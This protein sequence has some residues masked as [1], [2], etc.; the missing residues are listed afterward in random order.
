[1]NCQPFQFINKEARR[2]EL[3]QLKKAAHEQRIHQAKNFGL[4]QL[5]ISHKNIE[6]LK[7]NEDPNDAVYPM[8]DEGFRSKVA[9]LTRQVTKEVL[10]EALTNELD[11]KLATEFFK[12]TN[13]AQA[14][15][16]NK[17]ILTTLLF[18]KLQNLHI[19]SI[20]IATICGQIVKDPNKCRCC[21]LEKD[22]KVDMPIQLIILAS[23]LVNAKLTEPNILLHYLNK[24]TLSKKVVKTNDMIFKEV[25]EDTKALKLVLNEEVLGTAEEILLRTIGADFDDRDPAEIIMEKEPFEMETKK[26]AVKKVVAWLDNGKTQSLDP[27]ELAE[28]ALDEIMAQDMRLSTSPSMCSSGIDTENESES[29]TEGG[30]LKAIEKAHDLRLSTDSSASE[31]ETGTDTPQD[32][33]MSF[34][35][36][37]E[38]NNSATSEPT[39]DSNVDD[40]DEDSDYIDDKNEVPFIREF[41][42]NENLSKLAPS[43]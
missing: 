43:F 10:K 27:K 8:S 32:I 21:G 37:A 25:E 29:E 17:S 41:E 40:S 12:K 36:P 28:K 15:I 34:S 39:L 30:N 18:C 38:E 42:D 19:H 35:K 31:A 22:F 24:L 7:V 16:E 14:V 5:S 20:P 23:I 4:T 1:M 9:S 13:W 26:E 11:A 6:I 2:A 3:N 33:A